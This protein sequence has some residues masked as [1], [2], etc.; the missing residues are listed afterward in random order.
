MCGLRHASQR[1]TNTPFTADS[2]TIRR[3]ARRLQPKPR[4]SQNEPYRL[5]EALFDRGR[6][7]GA[8]LVEMVAQKV[9]RLLTA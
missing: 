1:S 9:V 8:D 3:E 7:L 2:E 6:G 4:C 5:K